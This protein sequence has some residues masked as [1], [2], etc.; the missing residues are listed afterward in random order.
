VAVQVFGALGVLAVWLVASALLFSRQSLWLPWVMPGLSITLTSLVGLA[1]SYASEAGQRRQLKKAFGHYVGDDVLAELIRHPEKLAL[2]GEKRTLTVFFSDIRDFTTL[3]EKLSPVELVAFLNTYLSPMTQAVLSQGG[4]LDK[5]I[6]DAVMAV[7]GAPVPRVDHADQA[8]SCVLQMHAELAT[9]NAGALQR[10]NLK[11][12][13]GVGINTGD[14]VVGNMGSAERFDYTVAG[15]SVNLA[16]RLEGLSKVYGVYCLVGD[17]T[18]RAAGATFTFR[19]L[20]LVQV[21]GKHEAVPVHELLAGPGLIVA[22]WEAMDSWNT[23]LAAFRAG[24]LPEARTAFGDFAKANPG[25]LAVQ[26]YLERLAELPE[27]APADFQPV[28]TFKSK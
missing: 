6:G 13:I 21:K 27:L 20:D 11:V 22:R 25:D 7:F 12:A 3:S 9:L 1:L 16:S 17:G 14:M 4:L 18:R 15:D 24:K 28:T 26:R 23:G 19:E 5:Y 10:F 2:G 8:L